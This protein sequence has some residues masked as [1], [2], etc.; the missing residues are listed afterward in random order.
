MSGILSII[1]IFISLIFNTSF[2]NHL[3]DS[4][5]R[6]IELKKQELLA[7]PDSVGNFPFDGS[8]LQSI[9]PQAYWLLRRMMLMEDFAET[10][11]DYWAW[12]LAVNENIEE[13]TARIDCKTFSVDSALSTIEKNVEIYFEKYSNYSQP[14]INSATY[15]DLTLAKYRTIYGYFQLIEDVSYHDDADNKD[16]VTLY[17]REYKEWFEIN[18]ITENLASCY[19]FNIARYSSSPM[20]YNELAANRLIN[21]LSELDIERSVCQDDNSEPFHLDSDTIAEKDFTEL[22]Y[23]YKEITEDDIIEGIVSEWAE[24]DYDSARELTDGEFDFM[25]ISETISKY[26]TALANWR[27]IRKHIMIMLPAKKQETYQETTNMMQSRLYNDL[28][29]IKTVRY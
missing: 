7:I 12:M 9:D 5:A 25:K 18:S 22:I 23:Y 24:K 27:E 13:Y 19:T 1:C 26:E 11:D 6:N 3:T 21:R 4:E 20:E 8:K 15:I 28:L 14:E 17:Y 29:E 16:L 2:Q 10:Y